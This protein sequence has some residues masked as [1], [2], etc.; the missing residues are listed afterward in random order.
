MSNTQFDHKKIVALRH[1]FYEIHTLLIYRVWARFVCWF[2][3]HDVQQTYDP[4]TC[5]EELC[6][7]CG[8]PY[9]QERITLPVL[10]NRTYG[11]LVERDWA[12]FNKLDLYLLDFSIRLP[13]WWEY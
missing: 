11:W 7:R 13:S 5:G 4:T 3:G 1:L 12:W 8:V 6:W 9:P 10:L 2:L